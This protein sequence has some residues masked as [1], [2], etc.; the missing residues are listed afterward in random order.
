MKILITSN[1]KSHFNTYIDFV[2]YYLLNYFEK[3]KFDTVIVPNKI[4]IT[5]KKLLKLRNIK[6]IVL[7]G[8]NDVLKKNILNKKRLKVEYEI[9]KFGIKKNIPIIGI[10]RG[11][12]VLNY[13]F[14]G[15]LGLVKG[16]MNTRHKVFFKKNFFNSK[17]LIVNSFHNW[18]I[19]KKYISKSFESLAV[20]QKENV[21][22]FVHKKYKILG[23]MWHPEREKSTK[24]FNKILD[25]FK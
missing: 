1:F 19:P 22:M 8:G 13:F 3:K 23:V 17:I 21:E 4:E 6:L 16:H 18:G 9:I 7:P 14:K 20:D 11:M 15:K 12:Q 24:K 10:C 25:Y 5:K 2:D